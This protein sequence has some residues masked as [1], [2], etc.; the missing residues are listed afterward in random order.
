MSA[1][2]QEEM[3]VAFAPPPMVGSDEEIFSLAAALARVEM[4]VS[5]CG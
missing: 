1:A 5:K 2:A 4:H 3:F